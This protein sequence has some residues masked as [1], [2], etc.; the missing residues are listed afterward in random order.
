MIRIFWVFTTLI[1]WKIL[2][3]MISQPSDF[4]VILG[5]VFAVIYM[6]VSFKSDMFTKWNFIKKK[7]SV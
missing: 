1:L 4:S 2:A 7:K 5:F 3:E 6:Y